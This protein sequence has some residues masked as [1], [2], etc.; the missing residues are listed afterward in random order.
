M[1]EDY[2]RKAIPIPLNPVFIKIK[3]LLAAGQG[4]KME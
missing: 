4:C 1:T 2:D 3:F